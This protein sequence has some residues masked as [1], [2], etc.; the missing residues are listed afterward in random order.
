MVERQSSRLE[1]PTDITHEPP[2]L[3][4]IDR[5]EMQERARRLFMNAP[6]DFV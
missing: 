3:S 5:L 6:Q 1:H 4:G 2:F